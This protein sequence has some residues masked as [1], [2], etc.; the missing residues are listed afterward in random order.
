MVAP[1]TMAQPTAN[2]AP[3]EREDLVLIQ[4]EQSV[5]ELKTPTVLREVAVGQLNPSLEE[6]EQARFPEDMI[7]AAVWPEPCQELF[8]GGARIS[9]VAKK[10]H[11][12]A[13]RR[14]GGLHTIETTPS[15]FAFSRCERV[16][17]A[18]ILPGALGE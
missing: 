5:L 3:L 13:S 10:R 2:T 1:S 12:E 6:L 14:S 11:V 18:H 8:L 9:H 7:L 16:T 4:E 15:R 17:G